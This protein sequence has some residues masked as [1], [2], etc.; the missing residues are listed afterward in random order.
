VSDALLAQSVPQVVIDFDAVAVG[1]RRERG[2]PVIYGDATSEDVLRIAR[3]ASARLAI[4]SLPEQASAEAVVRLLRKMAPDLPIIAR[5]HSGGDMAAMVRAGADAVIHAEFE[6]GAQ[7]VRE[8]LARLAV[9]PVSIDEYIRK[10]R[11]ERYG[12]RELT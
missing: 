9:P 11:E 10:L 3:P 1:R 4:V 7:M 6:A 12:R 2:V 8:T 5:V